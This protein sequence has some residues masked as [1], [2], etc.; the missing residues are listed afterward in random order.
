M[1]IEQLD[2]YRPHISAYVVCMDCAHDWVAVVPANV[3]WPLECGE[4]GAMAGETVQ[5]HDVDWFVRFLKGP[6]RGQR[7]MVLINAKRME[8]PE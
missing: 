1:T 4:C 2:D 6:N 3:Q 5:I 8:A 7:E